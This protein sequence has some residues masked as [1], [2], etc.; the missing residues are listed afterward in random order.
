MV[1]LISIS[2]LG[3]YSRFY[4]NKLYLQIQ[5]P[6]SYIL[7]PT[8]SKLIQNQSFSIKIFAMLTALA[9]LDKF[10]FFFF[11]IFFSDLLSPPSWLT[12]TDLS[13]ASWRM[14]ESGRLLDFLSIRLELSCWGQSTAVCRF[15][16]KLFNYISLKMEMQKAC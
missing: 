7:K 12:L 9:F 4:K 1:Y 11:F 13:R 5:S 8:R 10:A 2:H 16:L 3:Q 14:V 15:N 6:S